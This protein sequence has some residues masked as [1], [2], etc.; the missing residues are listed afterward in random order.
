MLHHYLDLFPGYRTALHA[1]HVL[2]MHVYLA[3]RAG[4]CEFES[5]SKKFCVFPLENDG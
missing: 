2:Y 4:D 5:C 1:L 3:P